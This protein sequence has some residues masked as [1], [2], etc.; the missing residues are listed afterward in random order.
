MSANA[1]RLEFKH[2]SMAKASTACLLSAID[3]CHGREA[4][5][6]GSLD[7]TAHGHGGH[8]VALVLAH[9]MPHE[10]QRQCDGPEQNHEQTRHNAQLPLVLPAGEVLR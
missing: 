6:S 3:E 5:G 2:G 1:C 7:E 4:A 9:V 8:R 10:W